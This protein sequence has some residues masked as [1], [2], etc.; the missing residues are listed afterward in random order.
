M[1]HR[2]DIALEALR[3][4]LGPQ[5]SK[6]IDSHG[7]AVGT[8]LVLIDVAYKTAVTH[9][10]TCDVGTNADNIISIDDAVSGVLAHCDVADA[11]SV[12]A[13]CGVTDGRVIGAV[14]VA[15]K[16]KRTNGRV[17]V[18]I[19][20]FARV[21]KQRLIADSRVARAAEVRWQCCDTEGFCD[22]MRSTAW[23]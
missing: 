12:V 17:E 8:D 10:K 20:P 4:H 18:P 22:R 6:G 23:L 21:A 2:F 19:E 15:F 5:L 11:E 13:K 14:V 9:V 1:V 7:K 16:R 3:G